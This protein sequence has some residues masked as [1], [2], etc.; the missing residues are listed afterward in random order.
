VTALIVFRAGQ[1]LFG[2]LL[3]PAALALLTTAFPRRRL[4]LVLGVWG[5]VNALA[6]GLGPVVA[7]FVVQGLGWP[8]VFLLNVPIALL[9]TALILAVMGESRAG[10]S[11]RPLRQVLAPRSV[12]CA[13]VLVAMSSFAVFGV[14]FLLTLFL[15]N[16]RGLTPSTAGAWLLAPTLTVVVGALVGGVLSERVGPARPVVL[17]MLAVA[18]GLVTLAQ[19]PVDASFWQV[20]LPAMLIGLGTGVWVIAAMQTII[21]ES[22]EELAGTA[23]AVQQSASQI[24]GVLGLLVLGAVVSVG[25]S[26]RLATGL[27]EA[28]ASRA[29]A[30]AVQH[31]RGLVLEGRAPVLRRATPHVAHLVAS[32]SHGAFTGGMHTAFLLLAAL[33]VLAAPLGLMLRGTRVA[34]ELPRTA[35]EPPAQLA[36]AR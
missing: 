32:V 9:A 12:R 26:A 16:V 1:G 7:G 5:G 29:V 34:A 14:L 4:G 13:A 28:G 8:A 22:G 6:I 3:Q 21:I 20:G 2:A 30:A 25:V 18:G 15:Q 19:V 24:G 11:P 33:I 36:G 27:R 31:S 17:G 10:R 35:T 23:S